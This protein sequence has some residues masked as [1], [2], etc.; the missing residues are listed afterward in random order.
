MYLWIKHV[1]YV[2][3]IQFLC[4]PVS[5]R[6]NIQSHVSFEIFLLKSVF[7]M[8]PFGAS[9]INSCSEKSWTFISSLTFFTVISFYLNYFKC[10]HRVSLHCKKC[11][12]HTSMISMATC[13]IKV[14]INV[15]ILSHW[16]LV[17]QGG[18]TSARPLRVPF[19]NTNF[20]FTRFV[21]PRKILDHTEHRP[22]YQESQNSNPFCT[23]SVHF[24][25]ANSFLVDFR[26]WATAES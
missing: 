8:E 17:N 21:P 23:L 10:F 20:S 19:W 2:H 14:L 15:N 11:V 3:N 12:I 22:S 4:F 6:W 18:T 5:H 25:T 13:N 9:F 24:P 1:I 26:W 7:R 16:T